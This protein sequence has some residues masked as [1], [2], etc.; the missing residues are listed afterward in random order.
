MISVALLSD[1][2]SY[3]DDHIIEAIGKPDIILHAGDIG[4]IKVLDTLEGIAPVKAVYGNIDDMVVR[5][6][7]PEYLYLSLESLSVFMIHIAGAPGKY[8]TAVRQQLLH[9]KPKLF[10]CG[11]SHILR[12]AHDPLFDGLYMNPGAAGQHGFHVMRTLILFEVHDTSIQHLK[13]VELGKRGLIP[14]GSTQ[15]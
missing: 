7:C 10:I 13:V 12:I 15:V 2:H 6:H 11:H 9:N 1:T 8:T 14:S 5:R 3:L 4:S